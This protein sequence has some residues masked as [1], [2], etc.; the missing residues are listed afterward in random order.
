MDQEVT[1]CDARVLWNQLYDHT[2][3]FVH[4]IEV[5]IPTLNMQFSSILGYTSLSICIR[6]LWL[7]NILY[8]VYPGTVKR[9]TCS[10]VCTDGEVHISKHKS[11]MELAMKVVGRGSQ[12]EQNLQNWGN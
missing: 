7:S 8:G 6:N 10:N 4:E 12:F 9:R 3:V 5:N 1:E 11:L 2:N